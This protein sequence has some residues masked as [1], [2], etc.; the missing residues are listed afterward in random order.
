MKH[1]ILQINWLF[2]KSQVDAKQKKALLSHMNSE[3]VYMTVCRTL[4]SNINMVWDTKGLLITNFYEALQIFFPSFESGNC[5][6]IKNLFCGQH[7]HDIPCWYYI[8]W[9]VGDETW[10]NALHIRELIITFADLDE[11]GEGSDDITFHS[12]TTLPSS[13][14]FSLINAILDRQ[15]FATLSL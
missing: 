10:K 2:T 5:K 1:D 9:N 8:W 6:L 3:S 13:I 4:S 14:L 12:L 15:T 11:L 7:C